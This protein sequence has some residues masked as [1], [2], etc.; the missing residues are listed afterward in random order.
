MPENRLF[1]P[2]GLTPQP[3]LTL[4]TLR[5]AQENHTILEAVAQRCDVNHTLHIPLGPVMGILPRAEAIAPWISGSDRDIA[6]LSKVGKR[7]CFTVKSISSDEKGS[8]VALLS[9]RDVQ[10]QAYEYLS[11]HLTPGSVV[12]AVVTHLTSFG[13]FA[14][15]GCGIIAMLP[16]EHISVSRISHPKDRFR[17]GQ[18][19]L[20]VIH[21]TDPEKHRFTLTHKEL[22]G[23]WMENASAFRAGETVS[24]II[25][26]VKDYGC[27]VELTPNLSGLAD[28]REDLAPGD[29]VSV[30]IKS[31]CPERMKI[32]LHIIEKLPEPFLPEPISYK[33]ADGIIDRWVYSP[34]GYDRP[35]IE[36]DF[37]AS[38]P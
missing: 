15:I 10:K 23:T 25:R 29:G 13:V 11:K 27:F 26:S 18:K 1:L 19:I 36:T 32:K 31:I 21:S 4:K 37:T 5:S 28:F 3:A 6:V 34:I 20:A 35:A 38:A 9:R 22:L 30:Y 16:I 33:I 2:E 24:G 17:P 12:T 7:I 8:A 14:D